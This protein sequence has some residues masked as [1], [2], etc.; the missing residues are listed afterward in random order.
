M[1]PGVGSIQIVDAYDYM[2]A[3]PAIAIEPTG[4]NPFLYPFLDLIRPC[5]N[6]L[7]FDDWRLVW[8]NKMPI[9]AA[10]IYRKFRYATQPFL[11]RHPIVNPI[12]YKGSP[13]TRIQSSRVAFI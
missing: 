3:D 11:F 2:Q 7:K 13:Y 6:R 4:I 10:F 9:V 5:D 8:E 12:D 1:M